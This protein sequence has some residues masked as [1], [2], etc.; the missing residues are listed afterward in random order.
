MKTRN[1]C[2]VDSLRWADWFLKWGE[3]RGGLVVWATGMT[4]VVCPPSCR[5]RVSKSY[6]VP[7]F[8]PSSSEMAVGLWCFYV[9]LFEIAFACVQLYLVPYGFFVVC[10]SKKC[11]FRCKRSHKGSRVPACPITFCLLL[12]QLRLCKA[13]AMQSVIGWFEQPCSLFLLLADAL[14]GLTVQGSVLVGVGTVKVHKWCSVSSVRDLL[15][16]W[17]FRSRKGSASWGCAELISIWLVF[18]KGW[19]DGWSQNSGC[20]GRG[21]QWSVDLGALGHWGVLSLWTLSERL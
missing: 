5:C 6:A 20:P 19:K 21:H 12:C 7:C 13:V 16:F 3:G 10:C 8:A 4:C 2:P 15:S 14:N 11:L 1:W 18:K 9:L 17:G